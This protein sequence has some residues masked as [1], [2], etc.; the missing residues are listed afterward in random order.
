MGTGPRGRRGDTGEASSGGP[1]APQELSRRPARPDG[2]LDWGRTRRAWPHLRR[3]ARPQRMRRTTAC[4]VWFERT[5]ME[6][7]DLLFG[8][9]IERFEEL[10]LALGYSNL[11]PLPSWLGR[12]PS[13]QPLARDSAPALAS[14]KP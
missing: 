12:V 13:G 8:R 11:G 9:A 6:C 1:A 5:R 3:R 10:V 14:P 7:L 2:F 4:A